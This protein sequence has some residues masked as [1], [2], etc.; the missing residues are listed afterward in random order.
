MVGTEA[1]HA[2][3]KGFTT[4]GAKNH[5]VPRR[6]A[7]GSVVTGR[8]R[9]SRLGLGRDRWRFARSVDFLFLCSVSWFFVRSVVNSFLLANGSAENAH[10][11][12]L[13]IRR[14]RPGGQA[15]SG[16]MAAADEAFVLA[17]LHRDGALPLKVS[18]MRGGLLG[19]VAGVLAGC[20]AG[21][22]R[23]TVP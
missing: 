2:R 14:D 6:F 22:E 10:D 20:E 18:Q 12:G 17:R 4:E 23:Q 7:F 13:A 9:R 1:P 15:I 8:C 16:T 3:K 5:E 19:S 11:G 21:L